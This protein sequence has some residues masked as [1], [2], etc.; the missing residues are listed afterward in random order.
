MK[1]RIIVSLTADL[2]QSEASLAVLFWPEGRRS[3]V[4]LSNDDAATI[5]AAVAPFIGAALQRD[6][7]SPMKTLARRV[8]SPRRHRPRT[9]DPAVGAYQRPQGRTNRPNLKRLDIGI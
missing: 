2:C 1:H 7:K 6:G 9:G 3:A 5:R 8:R 4:D